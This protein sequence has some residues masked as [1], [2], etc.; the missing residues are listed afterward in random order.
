MRVKRSVDDWSDYDALP[1]ENDWN[2]EYE[3]EEEEGE[4]GGGGEE[5]EGGN[6][7]SSVTKDELLADQE[8]KSIVTLLLHNDSDFTAMNENVFVMYLRLMD[9][10][11]ELNRS[12]TALI[13]LEPTT[14]EPLYSTT[15]AAYV[16]SNVAHNLE[17]NRLLNR[18]FQLKFTKGLN[19]QSLKEASSIQAITFSSD[20]TVNAE[21]QSTLAKLKILATR[22]QLSFKNFFAALEAMSTPPPKLCPP[23]SGWTTMICFSRFLTKWRV[24][25]EHCCEKTPTINRPAEHSDL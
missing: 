20:P 10:E 21:V 16:K 9:V 17:V 8:L 1:V 23:K 5:L 15:I 6:S 18:L 19:Y 12:L 11:A 4:E 3:M 24:G 25:L 13:Q 7:S 2:Q 22:Y 14:P